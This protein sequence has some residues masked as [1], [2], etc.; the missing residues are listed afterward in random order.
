LA[1]TWWGLRNVRPNRAEGSF[2]WLGAL[3]IS[4]SLAAL[5]IGLSAGG[6]LGQADFYGNTS[7]PPPYALPLVI[8]ALVLLAAFVWVERRARYPLLDLALFRDR[9]A[10]AASVINVLVG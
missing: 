7:G 2:D 3:L 4:A 8:A 6:E 10:S 9:S 1:L 5:N